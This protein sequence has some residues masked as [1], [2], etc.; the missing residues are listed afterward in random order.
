MSA[1]TQGRPLTKSSFCILICIRRDASFLNCLSRHIKTVASVKLLSDLQ[2]EKSSLSIDARD[3][4]TFDG[5]PLYR[6]HSAPRCLKSA[7][8]NFIQQIKTLT[9]KAKV[10]SRHSSLISVGK[11]KRSFTEDGKRSLSNY[12]IQFN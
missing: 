9:H 1:P 10:D 7:N 12:L 5:A 2:S 4:V 8:Y 3:I 11:L 6:S